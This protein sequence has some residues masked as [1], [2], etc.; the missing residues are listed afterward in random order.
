MPKRPM[1]EAQAATWNERVLA[2][3]LAEA[4]AKRRRQDPGPSPSDQYW[5]L[6]RA[7]TGEEYFVEGTE[8][9]EYVTSQYNPTDALKD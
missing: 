5:T 2:E 6:C 8:R 4:Q 3:R 7:W 9:N 1:T